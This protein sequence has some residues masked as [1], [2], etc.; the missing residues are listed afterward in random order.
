AIS[1]CE[2]VVPPPV[3]AGE[4]AAKA[5]H[6]SVQVVIECPGR[7]ATYAR[8]RHRAGPDANRELARREVELFQSWSK[9]IRAAQPDASEAD[10]V[11]RQI[12]VNGVLS[13]L[14]QRPDD[15]TRRRL[16]SLVT[17]GLVSVVTVPPVKEDAPPRVAPVKW[18]PPESRREQILR[19]AMR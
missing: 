9:G 13:A 6:S 18:H 5:M 7:L 15:L 2:L 17:D 8:E 4:L 1:T 3:G 16:L 11:V 12:A 14:A 19:V 10:L